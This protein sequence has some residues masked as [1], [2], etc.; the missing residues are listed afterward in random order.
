MGAGYSRRTLGPVA[1]ETARTFLELT[2]G[3][4]AASAKSTAFANAAALFTVS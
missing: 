3:L 2:Y 1:A 4:N